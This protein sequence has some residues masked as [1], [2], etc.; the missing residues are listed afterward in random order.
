MRLYCPHCDE[1]IAYDSS[2]AGA[3]VSCPHCNV[4]LKIPLPEELPKT[5]REQ[6]R[7]EQENMLARIRKRKE[8]K[9]KQR[10]LE[11]ENMLA[12]RRRKEEEEEKQRVL[13]AVTEEKVV[14]GRYPGLRAVAAVYAVVSVIGFI[15]AVIS[16]VGI[17]AAANSDSRD[18]SPFV[19]ALVSCVFAAL[20]CW[21]TS[22]LIGLFIDVADDM[23][24]T[25]L[26]LKRLVH[27][28]EFT[29]GQSEEA[30]GR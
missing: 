28:E 19:T 11:Q 2:K 6:L 26:L 12:R 9:Q 15:G 8:A 25:R 7:R 22:E 10:V 16:V 17:I 18:V 30:C 4:A 3:T 14:W 21:G 23:R 27:P 13:V 24:V 5:Q 29:T 1:A 20:L